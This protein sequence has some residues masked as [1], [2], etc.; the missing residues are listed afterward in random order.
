MQRGSEE[1]GWLLRPF[2]P[3]APSDAAS[4][5]A[6]PREPSPGQVKAGPAWLPVVMF[7]GFI[8][9]LHLAGGTAL[10]YYRADYPAVIGLGVGAYFFGLR[11][12]FD[13]DHIAAIDDT[14]RLMLQAGRKPLGVG[15]FF[16]LGHSTVVLVCAMASVFAAATVKTDLPGLK[17]LGAVLGTAVSGVFLWVAGILNLLILMELLQL[18]SRRRTEHSHMH[19]D[20]LLA[21]RGLVRRLF[22]GRLR[23]ITRSWQMYPLGL[24]FGLGFDTASEI[25]LLVMTAAAASALPWPAA[26][27]LPVLFAAGM[28]VMDT[29]DGVLMTLAYHWAFVN[30]ARK[31][32]YNL[33][34][35]LLSAGVALVIG[36]LELIDVST[37]MFGVH[38]GVLGWL[39][40]L[41]IG[42][43]GYVIAGIFIAS[44]GLSVAIWKLSGMNRKLSQQHGH[45]HQHSSIGISHQHEHF[46]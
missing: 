44:W 31:I 13:A 37:H 1:R 16:S 35:T 25:S 8:A 33:F 12:A 24:L 14:V 9:L 36:T 3:A 18:W 28:S 5:R 21:Q 23:F 20:E 39:S 27:A 41:D 7:Y 43:L 40:R 2:K 6:L 29:T 26:L 15:F 46:H 34:T 42:S 45:E 4:L 17:S 19:L 32:A 30:P 10:L 38:G 11:H 22:G